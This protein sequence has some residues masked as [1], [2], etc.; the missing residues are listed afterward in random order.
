[1]AKLEQHRKL[2]KSHRLA[3]NI[4]TVAVVGYT[5]A[6]KT[7]LIKALTKDASMQPKNQ[8]FATLGMICAVSKP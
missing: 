1:V 6:G 2:I 7:S 4:P 8:L 5:N 3:I